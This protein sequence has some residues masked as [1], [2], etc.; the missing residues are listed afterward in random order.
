[1]PTTRELELKLAIAPEDAKR[2]R[3]AGPLAA[4]PAS[5]EHQEAVYFD[6]PEHELRKAGLSLR[7]RRSGESMIQTV[8]SRANGAG[9]FDRD[10]WE[11][12]VRAMKPEL[13]GKDAGPIGRFSE[14]AARLDPIARIKIDRT[15]WKIAGECDLVEISLD[16]GQIRAGPSTTRISGLELELKHGSKEALFDLCEALS[17]RVPL[18]LD[19]R[20]KAELAEALAEGRLDKPTKAGRVDVRPDMTIGQG[21]TFIVLSCL[22]HLRLNEDLLV[23][24]RDPEALHQLRVA[25]RRLLS[26][27][28]LFGPV[29]EGKRYRKLT[30]ELSWFSSIFGDVRNLDTFIDMVEA[31]DP[32]IEKLRNARDRA[33][34]RIAALL[35]SPRL[36]KLMI[37]M[38]RW[39]FVG[40]WRRRADAG[41]PLESFLAWRLDKSWTR[42]SAL[43]P[44]LQEMSAKERHRF[45]LRVKQFRYSLDFA[46]GL[47]RGMKL[48]RKPFRHS[49]AGL[50]DRLG[51]LNDRR[52][53]E[54]LSVRRGC[55]VP[56]LEDHEIGAELL[57]Q[58]E[59]DFAEL[60]EIGP[61][62]RR[63]RPRRQEAAGARRRASAARPGA[64]RKRA[65]QSGESA[66]G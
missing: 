25:T 26:A 50:Q 47:H 34:D 31:E 42:I 54:H 46:R 48:E 13:G 51:L 39:L 9:M 64:S 38:V 27:F 41:A 37:E 11:V 19:V 6:T 12:P 40:S 59:R 43:G 29:V 44:R 66:R 16:Q 8:K 28:Q 24:G 57:T 62:W 61:Y 58:A 23:E 32:E 45:R 33:Y 17:R 52:V 3:L 21:F 1:M 7:V 22:R 4:E 49:L 14:N 56:A 18:R 63:A 53:A 65:P 2:L 5:R 20:S 15:S 30:R 55:C 35:Q 36:P 60:L 10:E